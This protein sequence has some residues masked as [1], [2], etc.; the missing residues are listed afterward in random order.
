MPPPGLSPTADESSFGVGVVGVGLTKPND[1]NF[2][3]PVQQFH[4]NRAQAADVSSLLAWQSTG[5]D[6][7]TT[8][9]GS[10]SAMPG[11]PQP[12]LDAPAAALAN[13]S[14]ALAKVNSSTQAWVMSG[15]EHPTCRL[16]A[17]KGPGYMLRCRCICEPS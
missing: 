11:A 9:F 2:L 14:S 8:Q 1:V 4:T 5:R 13:A 6:T 12:D 7:S 17:L 15:G 10:Q 16:G 3:K